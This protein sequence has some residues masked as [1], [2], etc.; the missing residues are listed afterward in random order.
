VSSLQI[1]NISKQFDNHLALND[2]SIAISFGKTMALLGHNGA[3]KSTLIRIILQI[4]GETSGQVLLDG[5]K[6]VESDIRR[7]GYLPEERGLY[8]GMK[9]LDQLVY[10]GRLRGLSKSRARDSGEL[11]LKKMNLL[12][13]SNKPVIDLSKGMQQ[14]VQFIAAIIH[15]PDIIILDEPFSGFDPVS[16]QSM[17][18]IILE[19]KAEGKTILFSSHQM[20]A[21]EEICDE[22]AILNKSKIVLKGSLLQLK[23]KY[24]SDNYVLLGKG[25]LQSNQILQ[26]IDQTN[27]GWVV[28][29][30]KEIKT[31][32]EYL[33]K[34]IVLLA[35]YKEQPSL[36]DIFIK[37]FNLG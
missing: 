32:I 25:N 11:W 23:E 15:D 20:D 37:S 5:K 33:N 4:I 1:S 27:E 13:W 19:L 10:F 36:T 28:K 30:L 8:K 16:V 35:F 34:E 18:A 24:G 21:V 31:V 29:P 26:I 12:S 2:V 9:V 14:K 3:G 22:I 7:F 17:I 6:L